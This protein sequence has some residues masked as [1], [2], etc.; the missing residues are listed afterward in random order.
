MLKTLTCIECPTGCTLTVELDNGRVTSVTGHKCPKGEA[1]AR[2][3]LESPVR[4]LTTTV[5]AEGLALS[6]IPV[7]TDRPIPKEKLR[8]AMGEI[9][10]VKVTASIVQGAVIISNLLDLNVAVVATRG[11]G[12]YP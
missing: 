5:R 4:I 11:A 1:Y 3:E 6:R 7:R 2:Q 9:R 8:E 12:K 10:K